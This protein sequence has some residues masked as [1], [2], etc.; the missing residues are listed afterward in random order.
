MPQPLKQT[1]LDDLISLSHHLG[2]EAHDYVII[3]E[4]NTSARID[5]HA[6]WVKASGQSLLSIE[7]G[8]FV[9]VDQE[10][11]LTLLDDENAGDEE[12]ARGLMDARVDPNATLRPS[13]EAI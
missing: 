7:P 4:G 3:G 8:G 9:E 12:I 1:V 10:R 2:D 11:L 5:A 13:V 6:F